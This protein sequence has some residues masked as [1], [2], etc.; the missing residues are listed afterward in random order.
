M[1][2]ALGLLTASG[3]HAGEPTLNQRGVARLNADFQELWT[4]D[5]LGIIRPKAWDALQKLVGVEHDAGKHAKAKITRIVSMELDCPGAPGFTRIDGKAIDA[6]IPLRG[7]WNLGV[8]VDVHVKGKVVGIKIDRTYRVGIELDRFR[9]TLGIDVDSSDP[10]APKVS[11]V[12]RPSIDF[13]LKVKSTNWLLKVLG[14]ITRPLMNGVADVVVAVAAQKLVNEV[15]PILK[16][17]PE[18]IGEAGGPGLAPVAPANLDDLAVKLEADTYEYRMPYGTVFEVITDKD[19]YGTWED[20]L[21]DP[22]F[23]GGTMDKAATQEQGDSALMTGHL[24]AG[25]CFRWATTQSPEALDRARGLLRAFRTL[26][27]MKG[28]P[29]NLNRTICPMSPEIQL[30]AETYA[31]RFQGV[32]YVM[33][34]YIS[35]D[36]YMGTFFGLAVA[37]SILTDPADKAEAGALIEMALDYLVRNHWTWR[38]RD[39]SFGERWQGTLEH[40]YAWVLAGHAVNP[41]KYARLREEYAGYAD[42]MWMGVWSGM[43]D[44]LNTYY[45]FNL[46]NG[47]LY[48]ALEHEHDP[49]RWQRA[50]QGVAVMRHFIGHHQ[51]A[52][53]NNTYAASDP[54]SVARLGAENEVLLTRWMRG[55][56]RWLN[57]DLRNDP[58][59][60]KVTITLPLPKISDR[61]V[62]TTLEIA[63]HPIPIDKR[64]STGFR[65]SRSPF[66]LVDDNCSLTG[67]PYHEGEAVDFLLPYW[68]SRYYGL[69]R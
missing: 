12:R 53:F 23:D 49:V 45:G 50:Y 29:G 51:N 62:A 40:Q 34:D 38:K 6:A 66:R 35:R 3:A 48:T 41:T 17:Q 22:A 30:D 69:V 7:E 67:E 26:L 47:V 56:R 37:H 36:A 61:K 28:E 31:Q 46:L 18:V 59:I 42:L 68:M 5:G 52:H 11:R 44:P 8:W 25:H 43:T 2:L 15:T 19:Y 9:A 54:S 16:D 20:S 64:L 1:V 24:L 10:A 58:T 55:P 4:Q 21:L 65:W 32:D 63:K 57:G 13:R 60:E 39:G 33:S 14:W 27:T